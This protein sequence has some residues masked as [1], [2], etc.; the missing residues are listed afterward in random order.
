MSENGNLFTAV[1]SEMDWDLPKPLAPLAPY[2]K[3]LGIAGTFYNPH[4]TNQHGSGQATLSVMPTGDK[5]TPGGISV[6]RWIGKEL[7]PDDAFRST[8]FAPAHFGRLD[9]PA[10]HTSADGP[11]QPVLVPNNPVGAFDKY[12][13]GVT[14]TAVPGVDPKVATS[15]EKTLI[16]AMIQDVERV[17]RQLVGAE[18]RKFDQII[19][20]TQALSKRISAREQNAAALGKVTRP[21]LNAT[22]LSN[23]VIR[24][25]SDLAFHTLALGLTHVVHLSVLGHDAF[26]DG[27]GGLGLPYDAH[28]ALAHG[29][30]KNMPDF[31]YTAAQ[32][33]IIGF[34]A[35]EIAYLMDQLALV[36]EENGTM[37][38][39]TLVIWVNSGGGKHHDGGATIPFVTV[40][41]L[42]GAWPLAG[43]YKF[44]S[45]SRCISDAFVSVA[46]AL[47]LPAQS[48]GD[49]QECKGPVF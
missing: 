45:G 30:I 36:P 38:D 35:A 5:D 19:E 34:H 11:G 13:A 28:E 44:V 25:F 40:G 22:G 32:H 24:G 31:D 3:K 23:E 1:R 17:R 8:V 20:S 7:Y 46:N 16:D 14:G 27:W 43:R 21:T 18:K 37:A 41:D 10:E 29:G 48:F 9:N 47:G 2:K 39:G 4:G 42:G 6:D 33:K 49:P 12:L 26:N 15:Q